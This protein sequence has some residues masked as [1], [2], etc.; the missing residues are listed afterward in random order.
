MKPYRLIFLLGILFSTSVSAQEVVNNEST[1]FQLRQ[2]SE[3]IDFMVMDTVLTEKKPV[4]LWCQG[5]LP[6]PL[7]IQDSSGTLYLFGGGV[8]NFDLAEIRKNYHLVVISMPET[9]F[10]AQLNELSQGYWYA[11]GP[12][13]ANP[14]TDFVKADY[15]D[16][17]VE[18]AQ[19]VLRF[20]V[21]QKWVDRS[22]LIVAGHS[23]GAK[24][25][26]QIAV[27]ERSVTKLGVFG[28]NPFGRVD[29]MIRQAR[30]DAES[31]KIS[32]EEADRRMQEEVA[33]YERANDP[34][35]L[36]NDPGLLAWKTFSLPFMEQLAELEIPVYMVYGTADV[37]A[38]LCDLAPLYAIRAGKKNLTCV[39]RIGEEH[40][41]FPVDENGQPDH[42][43]G[44]WG[45]VMDGFV[46]WTL[47]TETPE[48]K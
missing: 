39:R 4:F 20:L 28:G 35:E 31:G 36:E 32:W 41:F 19:A 38:D 23:Q 10:I 45:E 30:K 48:K 40:N 22:E 13:H 1:H 18:R 42:E 2:K 16:H 15:L 29:Q 6:Y 5:S 43:N 33:Q 27:R 7:Y 46:A 8:P 14:T 3:T 34:S 11:P 24:V 12:E 25:A 47:E 37:V 21:K 26:V 44:K 9:P 17:Y